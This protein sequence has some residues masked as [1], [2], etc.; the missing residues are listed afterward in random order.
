M[1]HF[2]KHY[3]TL[4]NYAKMCGVNNYTITDRVKHKRVFLT[5]IGKKKLVNVARNPIEHFYQ[6]Q[7][8]HRITPESRAAR[9]S[10]KPQVP[11][12]LI[13]VQ[14]FAA[15]RKMRTDKIYELIITDQLEAWHLDGITFVLET[16]CLALIKGKKP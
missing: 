6:T 10:D 2:F 11:E 16:D 7:G 4:Q 1:I 13:S 9:M 14:E 15:K 8:K 5:V 12:G 3:K